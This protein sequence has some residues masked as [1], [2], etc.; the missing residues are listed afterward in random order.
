MP[1][2]PIRNAEVGA[3]PETGDAEEVVAVAGITTDD[4]VEGRVEG[5]HSGVAAMDLRH[6]GGEAGGACMVEHV[7]FEQCR[8]E[9]AAVLGDD[10]EGVDE[11][12]VVGIDTHGDRAVGD[13]C[14]DSVDGRS[15]MD[16][17]DGVVDQIGDVGADQSLD[18]ACV[19][20]AAVSATK[21]SQRGDVVGNS[22]AQLVDRSH[23]RL[24]NVVR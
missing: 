22:W 10:T 12:G 15:D 5:P 8:E 18:F 2:G 20:L 1:T 6:D 21:R 19:T 16:E 17:G 23:E 9:L 4:H 14:N 7:L 11:H 24:K 13:H 3:L